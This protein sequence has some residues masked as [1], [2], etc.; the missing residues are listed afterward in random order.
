M[1]IFANMVNFTIKHEFL[2]FN[3]K[4]L[5]GNGIVLLSHKDYANYI[6]QT[7]GFYDIYLLVIYGKKYSRMVQVKFVEDKQTT[8]LQ[9]F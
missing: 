4:T 6:C 2:W 8:S 5:K 3:L 9:I 1:Q 7:L